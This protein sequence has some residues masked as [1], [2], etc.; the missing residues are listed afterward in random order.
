[1]VQ[2]WQ[3]IR[4]RLS[5]SRELV[6]IGVVVAAGLAAS[7]TPKFYDDDPLWREP[8]LVAIPE[9]AKREIVEQYEF[10]RN[11]FD[12]PDK[13]EHKEGAA[14]RAQNANTMDEVPD[15]TWYTNRFGA[16]DSVPHQR[17]ALADLVLG[18]GNGNQP[19]MNG[20]W[21]VL[22]NKSTGVTPGF[23][24]RDSTGKKFILKFD[25]ASH[26]DLTTAV[27]VIGSKFFYD[28]GYNVPE[29][30][31]VHFT[32]GQL[33]LTANSRQREDG[34]ERR[35]TERDVNNILALTRCD[36]ECRYRAVASFFVPGDIIGPFRFTGTRSDDPNDIIRH[37]NRREL[38]GLYVFAAWLNHTDSKSGNTLD[39]L[40]DENGLSYIKHYLVDFGAILGSATLRPKSP[41]DGHE[42]MFN[43]K[44]AAL[45]LATLGLDAP[46]WERAT[47]RDVREA[48]RFDATTFDP[49]H[50]KPD[51]P[52]VAFDIRRPDDE[53]WGAKRVMAF[54]DADIRAI[55][56][57]GEYSD[58]RARDWIANALIG[59][60]DRIGR[61]FF[62]KLLPLDNF[63]VSDGRIAFDDLGV[64]YGFVQPRSYQIQW[65][66][67]DNR[68]GR[69]ERV[70]GAT[71][72]AIPSQFQDSATG[73]Y[74]A[75]DITSGDPRKSVTAYLRKT[76]GG[77]EVVGIDRSW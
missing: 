75:A 23:I 2:V 35:M 14:P 22:G 1:M 40:V 31:I 6:L 76:N 5:Q 77:F 54:T 27:E 71:G 45:Q 55:V 58:P 72:A 29:N 8:K 74:F 73:A 57:T 59:R 15:C 39:S 49:E 18:P 37:E 48:G 13:L 44:P 20:P 28:L 33:R 25:P 65:S 21:T 50:W 47:Y 7:P 11:T 24:I 68:G 36:R 64:H 32:R 17:M 3:H 41:A 30:H 66:R 51:Y 34:R 60:R 38:R 19:S 12:E 9:A 42:Y 52:N 26:P 43:I 56:N 70:S 61:A 69:K 10:A 16:P 67:F 62:S 63:R 46:P 53:F 4:Q